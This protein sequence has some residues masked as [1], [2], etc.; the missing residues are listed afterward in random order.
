[1]LKQE[2]LLVPIPSD[3]SYKYASLILC[4]LGPSFGALKLMQVRPFSTV[5]IT[6]L[7]PVGLGGVINATSMG[8]RVIGV[9]RN[10][11]RSRLA[12][13]IGADAVIDPTDPRARSHILDLTAG[14]GVDLALET[15]GALLY[16]RLAIDA[17]RRKG[18]V[19]FLAEGQELPIHVDRDLVQKGLTVRGSLD[20]NRQH[21]DELLGIIRSS[22]KILDQYVTHQFPLSRIG[23]AW[24]LQSSGDCG[25]VLID[26]W[27]DA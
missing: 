27:G 26:P 6:G 25:K 4:G 21:T 17:T 10:P 11:Y 20:I 24:K 2:W 7:G 12:I 16:Q 9:A 23:E 1:M 19:T 15:S 13:A 22:G 8:A 3:L 5:L 14:R 18:E